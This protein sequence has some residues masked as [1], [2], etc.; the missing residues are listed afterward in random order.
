MNKLVLIKNPELFQGEKSL[1]KNK[2]YFEGWYFKNTNNKEGISF[3]PGIS[4]EN[5]DKKAFIQVIT[6][7]FSYFINYNINDFYFSYKTFIIKIGNSVF[8]KE[9]IHIDIKDQKQ[10]LKINGDLKYSKSININTNLWAPNIMG[11]FSY[12]PGMECNHA[13]LCMKNKVNGS[14]EFNDRL[15]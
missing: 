7:D 1:S 6:N 3:I 2:N 15:Y 9:S 5:N 13:I 8:S 14:I 10:N 11:P 4:N 12:A